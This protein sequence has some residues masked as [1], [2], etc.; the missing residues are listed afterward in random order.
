VVSSLDASDGDALRFVGLAYAISWTSWLVWGLVAPGS[1]M[2]GTGLFVLGGLGPLLAAALLAHVDGPGLRPWLA[3]IFRV[4]LRPRYYLLA[5][6]IPIGVI[7]VA[8]VVHRVVLGAEFTPELLPSAI[9]YPLYLG[10][11]VLL[12]GGLEEPGWRGY[13]Q[14]RLQQGRSALGASLLVGVVWTGWHAPLF[15]LPETLQSGIDP[16]LYVV[17]LLAMSVLLTWLTTVAGGSVVPAMVLHAGGNAILNYYPIGGA[18]GALSWPGLAILVGT[19]GVVA[20][21]VVAR[22]GPDELAPSSS[23]ALSTQ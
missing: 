16:A 18:V 4:R 22:Y 2:L 11:V 6:S 8:A 7:L 5:L 9:E 1:G 21:V 13:L 3:G 20:L 23:D 19:L 17:Q 14:P 10:V 15:V 12:G